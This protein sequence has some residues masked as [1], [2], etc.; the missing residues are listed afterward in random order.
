MAVRVDGEPGRPTGSGPL[1]GDSD[2][3]L[4]VLHIEDPPAVRAGA[5]AGVHPNGGGRAC[6]LVPWRWCANLREARFE[7][8]V[9]KYL[10]MIR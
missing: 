7:S 10:R 8:D 3:I 5:R 4:D 6:A 9:C 1:W 2:E